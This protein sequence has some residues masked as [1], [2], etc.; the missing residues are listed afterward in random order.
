[1]ILFYRFNTLLIDEEGKFCYLAKRKY[2]KKGEWNNVL[3][4]RRSWG[5]MIVY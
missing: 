5:V 3:W 2:N 1:M 4:G